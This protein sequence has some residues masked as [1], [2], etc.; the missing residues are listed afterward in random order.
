PVWLGA[1]SK[2]TFD[3]VAEYCDGWMP[4]GGMGRD[5]MENLNEACNKRGKKADDMAVA[6]F[7]APADVEQVKGLIDRGFTDLIFGLPQSSADKV[8]AQLDKVAKVAD[9]VRA[10]SH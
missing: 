7:G 5:G 1:N 10:A 6:L 2:W 3:R 8:L 9:E 4:I